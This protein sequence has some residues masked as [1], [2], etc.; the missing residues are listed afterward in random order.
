MIQFNDA[1]I[2]FF[3]TFDEA[4]LALF[5]KDR[6]NVSVPD[7]VL[8]PF[9]YVCQQ[10][11][12]D[13]DIVLTNYKAEI[14]DCYGKVLKDITSNFGIYGFTDNKGVNQI[15]FEIAPIRK[16]FYSDTVF[17][18]LSSTIGAEVYY[19]TPFYL[20]DWQS[21]RQINIDYFNYTD[22]TIFVKRITIYAKQQPYID[23]TESKTYVT[24]QG[25]TY[26]EKPII[27]IA[28]PFFIEMGSELQYT[29]L[30]YA[31]KSDI[32]FIN[33]VRMTN[34]PQI[35]RGDFIGNTCRFEVDFKAYFNPSEVQEYTP[36]I[37]Q[38]FAAIEFRPFNIISVGESGYTI[39]FNKNII[40][41]NPSES[42]ILQLYKYDDDTLVRNIE[43]DSGLIENNIAVS[44]DVRPEELEKYYILCDNNQFASIDGEPFSIIDKDTWT[45]TVSAPDYDSNDY[46]NDYLI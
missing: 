25:L 4:K 33:G 11:Y 31:L 3:Q 21:H 16:S 15:I 8:N 43:F 10:T 12:G 18:K 27:P 7:I 40:V 34:K 6:E 19:S 42:A 22:E 39:L 24:S 38:P 1:F 28:K 17:V 35:N 2:K 37:I 36:Q 29:A 41:T 46:S 44:N 26:S 20:M 5:A 30:I 45:F 14:I 23:E 13:F 32:V 9:S